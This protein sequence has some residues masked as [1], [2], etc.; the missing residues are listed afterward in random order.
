M[1]H[2]LRLVRCWHHLIDKIRNI[3][4]NFKEIVYLNILCH[5]KRLKHKLNNLLS[6]CIDHIVFHIQITNQSPN[7]AA[8]QQ[9]VQILKA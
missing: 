6:V 8:R 5:L 3:K 4:H 2:S 1:Y 9:T 7:S